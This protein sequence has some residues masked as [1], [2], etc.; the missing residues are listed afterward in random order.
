VLAEILGE[1][2]DGTGVLLDNR[3]SMGG[4]DV[5]LIAWTMGYEY[6]TNGTTKAFTRESIG[7]YSLGA[8]STEYLGSLTGAWGRA[9][10]SMVSW[11]HS[12]YRPAP[13]RHPTRSTSPT[14]R[15]NYGV[16][17]AGKAEINLRHERLGRL[18]A[19]VDRYLYYV[20]DGATRVEHLGT[21]R[22]G[23]YVNLYKGHGLG[24]S[25][26][27]YDV[28]RRTMTTPTSATPSGRANSTMS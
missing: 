12:R 20:A 7:V 13:S 1:A 18:Y 3:C 14:A 21:L 25:V 17:G 19:N 6:F 24:A 5:G 22:L 2:F 9:S 4:N 10:P 15:T 27:R 11:M 28:T 26:I 23:A 16:G 8:L